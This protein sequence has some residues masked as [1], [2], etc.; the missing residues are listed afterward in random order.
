MRVHFFVGAVACAYVG[1]RKVKYSQGC[2]LSSRQN[3]H[4]STLEC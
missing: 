3:L 2:R 1:V 4:D